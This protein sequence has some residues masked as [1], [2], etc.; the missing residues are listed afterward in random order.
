M[1]GSETREYPWVGGWQEGYANT[2]E[3]GLSRS[4]AVGMYPHGVAECGALDMAGNLYDWCQNDKDDP[5]IVDGFGNGNSKVL[6]GGSFS[7]YRRFSAAASYRS[8][9]DPLNVNYNFGLRLVVAAPIR[10]TKGR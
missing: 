7:S 9:Y 6:R 1:N 2:N 5:S 4:V 8:S 10:P 3:A